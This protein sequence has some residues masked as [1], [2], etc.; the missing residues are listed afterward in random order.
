MR[1]S[2]FSSRLEVNRLETYVQRV[3]DVVWEGNIDSGEG[4]RRMLLSAQRNDG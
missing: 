2:A 1:N 3:E 4:R